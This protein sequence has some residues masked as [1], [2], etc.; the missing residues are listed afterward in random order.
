MRDIVP[1]A[2]VHLLGPAPAPRPW[3]FDIWSPLIGAALAFLLSALAYR[4]RARLRLGWENV[5]ALLAQVMHFLRASAEERYR[6]LVVERA[7]T[8]ALVAHQA[9]LDAV[10]VEPRLL[11]PSPLSESASGAEPVV[12]EP[13]ALPL[14]RTLG[15]HPLYEVK[16]RR[17]PGEPHRCDLEGFPTLVGLLGCVARPEGLDLVPCVLRRVHTPGVPDL[18]PASDWFPR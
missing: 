17:E 6:E 14:H 12:A 7:R 9:P 13:R 1:P 8:L 15:G 4:F 5:L 2:I 16:S 10:F 18:S 11:P 3:R